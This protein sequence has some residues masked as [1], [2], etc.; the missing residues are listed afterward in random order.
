MEQ[1]VKFI[2]TDTDFDGNEIILTKSRVCDLAD[3]V[4]V[5]ENL[6]PDHNLVN[7]KIEPYEGMK[8]NE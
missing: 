1:V 8:I 2:L 7:I 4:E 6:F 5:A 3:C